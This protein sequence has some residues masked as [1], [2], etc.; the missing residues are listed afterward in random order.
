MLYELHR[1]KNTYT[2]HARIL[3]LIN[4]YTNVEHL[5]KTVLAHISNVSFVDK[6]IAYHSKDNAINSEIDLENT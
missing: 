4:T 1:Y 5:R 2:Q 3:T 6:N